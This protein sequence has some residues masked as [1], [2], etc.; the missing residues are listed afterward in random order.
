MIRQLETLP[1]K[2]NGM[3]FLIS[4]RN[5]PSDLYFK[6]VLRVHEWNTQSQCK[7]E[8]DE[9]NEFRLPFH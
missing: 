3:S 1:I 6:K 2:F 8:C 5:R 9:A 4:P 7:Q